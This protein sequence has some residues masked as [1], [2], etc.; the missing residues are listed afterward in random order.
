MADKLQRFIFDALDVRGAVVQLDESCIAIQNTHHYPPALA[1]L[2]NEFSVAVC[3]L[4]DSIKIAGTVTLQLRSAGSISL[5]MA[6]CMADHRV[7]AIAEYDAEGLPA[8]DAIDLSALHP[9]AVL[10]ITITPEKGDRYQGIVPIESISLEACLEDYFARSEQLPTWFRLLADKEQAIGIALHALPAEKVSN[11]DES[12]AHFSRLNLLLKT[13]G[14][15]EAFELTNEAILTRLY[16]EEDCR[17]FAPQKIE[18]GCECT[19][20]KS[21]DAIA[22][23]GAQEVTELVAEQRELGNTSITVDCHFCFQR[24]EFALDEVADLGK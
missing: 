8:V 23:L 14:Q 24:Y 11:V 5:I 17:L 6:D 13:L 12:K 16:H 4:R 9:D 2:L 22:S 19:A 3:L 18:F 1:T 20:Q 7:R 10:A 15:D 21:L